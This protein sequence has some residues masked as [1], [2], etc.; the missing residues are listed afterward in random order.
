M[1]RKG[2]NYDVGTVF[3]EGVT[4]R[5]NLAPEVIKREMEIIKNDLHCNAVRISGYDIGRL[6]CRRICAATG[7][8]SLVLT[9]THQ[10]YRARNTGLFRHLRQSCREITPAIAAC[11][12]YRWLRA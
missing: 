8:G 9:C 10:C 6:K 2:I 1:N 3:H 5:E 4:S 7:L 12:L 11:H